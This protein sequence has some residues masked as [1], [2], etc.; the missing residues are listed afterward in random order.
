[1]GVPQG[2]QWRFTQV[3]ARAAEAFGAEVRL[4]ARVEQVQ[5][6]DG[7]ATVV[8]ADGTRSARLVVSALDPRRTFLELVNPASFRTTW[9]RTS[10]G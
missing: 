1:M 8:L 3:L 6:D 5:T 2:R 4:N 9:S 10:A 7:R